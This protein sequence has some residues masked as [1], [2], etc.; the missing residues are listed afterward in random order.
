MDSHVSQLT[1]VRDALER[2]KRI[3]ENG[4]PFW[5]GREIME[6]LDYKDW[7]VFRALVERAKEACEKSGNFSGDH[8][9][10]HREMIEVGKGAQRARENLKLSKYACYLI[11]MNGDSAKPQIATAQT[12]FAVQTHK[13]ETE[14]ALTDLERRLLVRDRLRNANRRLSGAAKAAG[15]RSEMFGVFHDSGFKTLYGGYGQAEMKKLKH[16]PENEQLLDCMGRTELT[17]NEF[18]AVLTEDKLAKDKVREERRAIETHQKVGTAVRETIKS[19]GG[20]M[21][22]NLPAEASIKKLA[23]RKRKKLVPPDEGPNLLTGLNS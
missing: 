4:N 7:R 8:F 18:R 12:Y 11:A 6:I 3:H 5:I 14:E 2:K 22:E 10:V 1:Y 20:T 23:P 17:Y 16:I 21:P 15:V 13:Q 9:V 19:V